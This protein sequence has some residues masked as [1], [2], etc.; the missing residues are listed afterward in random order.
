M[1]EG[2][3]RCRAS[4]FALA[5]VLVAQLASVAM[6]AHLLFSQLSIAHFGV[7]HWQ[8]SCAHEQARCSRRLALG[9]GLSGFRRP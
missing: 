4:M 3:Q 7:L 9:V 8:L 6:P 1:A 5:F 2:G